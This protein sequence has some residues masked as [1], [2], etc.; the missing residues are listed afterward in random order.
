MG[1]KLDLYPGTALNDILI[2]KRI[3]SN[4]QHSK[5][6]CQCKCG[7][8]FHEYGYNLRRYG[9]DCG[10][11][12]GARIGARQTKHGHSI[13]HQYSPEYR[14]WAQMWQRCTNPRHKHYLRYGGRNIKVC[15][16]WKEFTI[17][18]NDL[19]P[20][21]S[22]VHTLHR[23]DNNGD[24]CPSNCKWATSKEQFSNKNTNVYVTIDGKTNYISEWCRILN[25]NPNMV[26]ARLHRG[27]DTIRALTTP[28]KTIMTADRSAI[29]KS[30]SRKGKTYERTVSKMLSEWSGV[31][32]RRRRV[33]GR[34]STTILV[35]SVADV[36]PADGVFVFSVE[37]K[38]QA[39]FS[40]D[41]LMA[42]PSSCAFGSWWLQACYDAQLRYNMTKC[43]TYPMLIFKPDPSHHWVAFSSKSIN[44]LQPSDKTRQIWERIFGP[45]NRLWFPHLMFDHYDHMPPIK[46]NISHSPKHKVEVSIQLD[47]VVLC[48]WQTFAENISPSNLITR[49]IEQIS[50]ME[51]S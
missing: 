38:N 24:Y 20:R 41:A 4:N 32:F 26:W 18:L 23:V 39:K 7:N 44:L 45:T 10:C 46:G 47:P 35:N 2:I 6:L 51:R 22:I 17:F 34:D 49:T 15:D 50:Q 11:K 31:K 27:W 30:N 37:A 16:Q 8:I 40:M 21:P 5:W 19:G 36:V 3:K 14:S 33:E 13:G 43:L 42:N 12:T 29:G 48:R 25:I 1:I 9:R 28:S